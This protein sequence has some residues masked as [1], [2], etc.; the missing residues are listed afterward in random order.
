MDWPTTDNGVSRYT[1]VA[2]QQLMSNSAGERL[3]ADLR[4][5]KVGTL[6]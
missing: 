3:L 4:E 2:S 6:A 1:A 5:R